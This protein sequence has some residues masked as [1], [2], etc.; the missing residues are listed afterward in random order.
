MTENDAEGAISEALRALSV[1]PAPPAVEPIAALERARE[2]VIEAG[3][4]I[5]DR[6]GFASFDA[7]L[8]HNRVAVLALRSLES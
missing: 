2:K 8:E 1:S 6:Q 4:E 7:A 3:K 5:S